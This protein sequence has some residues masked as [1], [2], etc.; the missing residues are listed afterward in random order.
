[1][2]LAIITISKL[3]ISEEASQKQV[4]PTQLIRGLLSSHGVL[5]GQLAHPEKVEG[6]QKHCEH[7]VCG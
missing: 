3:L 6:R 7:E 1:M 4:F 5:Q 2:K